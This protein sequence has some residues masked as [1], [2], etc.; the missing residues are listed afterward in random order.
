MKTMYVALALATLA[1][2]SPIYSIKDLGNLGGTTAAG[3]SINNSGAVTGWAQTTAGEMRAVAS[4]DGGALQVLPFASGSDLYAYGVNSSGTMVGTAYANGSPH[5][6]SWTTAGATDLGAGMY[7]TGVNDA[8]IVIGGNGHAFLLEN[9]ICHDLGVLPGGDWSA[10]YGI[11]NSGAV[12]GTASTAAGTF[13]GFIWTPDGIML[14]LGTLGGANSH[15]SGI[16]NNGQAIGFASLPSGYEHAFVSTGSGLTDLGSLGGSSYAYG[17]NDRGAVVGYG[18]LATGDNPHAFLYDAGF[19][20]DLN[21]LIAADSGWELLEAYGI[22]NHGQIAGE[23]IYHGQRSAFRLDPIAA[24][25]EPR[26]P[27]FIGLLFIV[28]RGL[29]I[30]RYSVN[31]RT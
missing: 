15:A 14:E 21:S 9:G 10:A 19:M 16:N 12:A 24:V 17:I 23:G 5:G 31:G 1:P 8:G 20:L 6:I 4:V 29:A 18:W 30:V 25:P 3:Y 26:L 27:I 13:R 22:N 2:A 28:W 7:V 11:N